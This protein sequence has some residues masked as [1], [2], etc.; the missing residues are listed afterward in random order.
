MMGGARTVSFESDRGVAQLTSPNS[1]FVP[2]Q[3]SGF[4][5]SQ[6]PVAQPDRATAF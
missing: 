1:D 4:R 3:E 6:A 5:V 2:R